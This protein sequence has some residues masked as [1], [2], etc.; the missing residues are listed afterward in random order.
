MFISAVTQPGRLL[1]HPYLLQPLDLT[2][3]LQ[4]SSNLFK[5]VQFKP[6]KKRAS[7]F[8]VVSTIWVLIQ[9]QQS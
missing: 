2:P 3:L 5:P 8:G 4:T 7:S 1:Q 9:L 6:L